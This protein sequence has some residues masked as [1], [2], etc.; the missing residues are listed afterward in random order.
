M[1]GSAFA[2][3]LLAVVMLSGCGGGRVVRATPVPEAPTPAPTARPTETPAPTAEPTPEPY[4]FTADA[5]RL[6]ADAG[7]Y[8]GDARRDYEALVDAALAGRES[9]LLTSGSENIAK[10]L[11]VFAASLYGP[12]V[13]VERN[14]DAATLLYPEG[15]PDPKEAESAAKAIAEDALEIGMN[16]TEKALALYRAVASGMTYSPEEGASLCSALTERKGGSGEFAAVLHYLFTQCGIEAQIAS[17]QTAEGLHFWVTAKLGGKVYHFDPTFEHSATDGKGLMYFGMSDDAM[18]ESGC[19][20]P[21]TL[22]L[23]GYAAWADVVCEES[24]YDDALLEVTAWELDLD[25]HTVRFAYNFS[26]NYTAEMQTES[27]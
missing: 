17:G 7:R 9:V 11:D 5:H 27:F 14:G 12:A 24:P 18:A 19:S 3:A 26:E 20:A 1:K 13:S 22:G 16:E 4:V 23:G 21:Y 10:V 25:T 8:L 15:R 6:S 2:A